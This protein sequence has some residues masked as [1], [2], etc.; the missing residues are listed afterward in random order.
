MAVTSQT[1]ELLPPPKGWKVPLILTQKVGLDPGLAYV[2]AD[3]LLFAGTNMVGFGSMLA[4]LGIAATL[5]TCSVMQPPILQKYPKIAAIAYDDRTPLRA[6]GLALLVVAGAAFSGGAMLPAAASL[7]F[8]VANI[9]LAESISKKHREDEEKKKKEIHWKGPGVGE[10]AATMIKRPEIYL[11]AGF[12]C[13]GFMAGG[14]ALFILP[15]VATAFVVGTKNALQGKPEHAGHPKLIT[16]SAAAV[17][18]AI[19]QANGHGLIAAAHLVNAIVLAEMERRVTPGG[20]V[21]IAKDMAGGMLKMAGL[22]KKTADNAPKKT[23][24][25]DP[26]RVP[27]P[28]QKPALTE[29][30]LSRAFGM[31]APNPQPANENK[32]VLQPEAASRGRRPAPKQP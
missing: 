18:A 25:P 15:V 5:K 31:K 24:T 12:A 14:A 29:A 17:F 16:A 9:R 30:D 21:Q 23:V 10:L 28:E 32:E 11:N 26:V 20:I 22:G 6:G 7:L 27:A 2:G 19:G 3:V 13:A 4:A 8:A 1:T